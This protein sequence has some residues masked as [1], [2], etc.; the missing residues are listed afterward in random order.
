[1]SVARKSGSQVLVANAWHHRTDAL[2]SVMALIGVLGAQMGLPI[3]DPVTGLMVAGLIVKT[4][5]SMTMESF[6]YVGEEEIQR[7]IT[8]Y[9]LLF[10]FSSALFLFTQPLLFPST[11]LEN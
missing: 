4:G 3:L 7:S 2:T 1:M 8:T 9:P 10:F 5:A 11:H 6:R